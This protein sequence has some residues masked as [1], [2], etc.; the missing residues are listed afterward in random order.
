[1]T[2]IVCHALY[3]FFMIL[4]SILFIYIISSWVPNTIK[5]RK[6]LLTLLDP[7]F[8]PIRYCLR[9]SVFNNSTIDLVPMVTL[10]VLSYLQS[11]FYGLSM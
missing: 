11:L 10:L 9:H 8:V 7:L 6:L 1:M 2:Y 3:I 5:I 4:E